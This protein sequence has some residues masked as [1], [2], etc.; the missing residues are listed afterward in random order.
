M[1]VSDKDRIPGY[2]YKCECGSTASIYLCN[3][4]FLS[5][6]PQAVG[7]DRWFCCDDPTCKNREGEEHFQ[8]LPDWITRG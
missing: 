1:F 3:S 5:K 7:E 4:D 8:D 2:I 6:R